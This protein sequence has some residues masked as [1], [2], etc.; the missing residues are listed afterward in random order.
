MSDVL[1]TQQVLQLLASMIGGGLAGSGLTAYINAQNAKSISR[2]KES[3]TIA[4]LT[5]ELRRAALMC[6]HNAKLH[7]DIVAPFIHFPTTAAVNA[8]FEERHSYPRLAH[9]QQEL[10]WYTLAI[11]QMNELIDL[12][13][14][15]L[16]SVIRQGPATT[17]T[18]ER[19]DRVRNDIVSKC[20]GS[21]KLEGVGPDDTIV[22]PTFIEHL[23]RQVLNLGA[24]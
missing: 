21:G 8:T 13:R 6:K 7:S 9:L 24:A 19:R 4:A 1:T 3:G 20:N 22:L 10:E 17:D 15:L 12:Y 14:L 11:I 23:L 2:A 16:P 18:E 5:G